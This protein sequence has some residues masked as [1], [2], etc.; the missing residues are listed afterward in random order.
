MQDA[1]CTLDNQNWTAERFSRLPGNRLEVLRRH[2]VCLSCGQFAWFRRES[3][4]G[5]PAHFCA[6]HLETCELRAVYTLSTDPRDEQTSEEGQLRAGD[7]IIVDLDD[8]R[9]GGTVDV[10]LPPDGAGGGGGGRHHVLPYSGDTTAHLTLRRLLHRLVAS[11]EFR[12]SSRVVTIFRGGEVYVQG[13][14]R[15]VLVPFQ[16]AEEVPP[17]INAFFWGQIASVGLTNDGCL[18]LNSSATNPRGDTSIAIF[19]DVREQ[20]MRAFEVGDIEE[21]I[22]AHV[23][24]GGRCRVAGTG[25]KTIWCGSVRNIVVRRYRANIPN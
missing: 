14:V 23:L 20:F 8:A 12:G 1:R 4:H 17:E 7:G 18:W 21:L 6:H 24:V 11:E 5:H 13:A 2:L 25:K 16:R 3:A 19:D 9:P 10:Q 22:G 15:D